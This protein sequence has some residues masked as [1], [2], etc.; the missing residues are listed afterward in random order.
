M[1]PTRRVLTLAGTAIALAAT[2]SSLPAR[3]DDAS[4]AKAV[5]DK[6]AVTVATFAKDPDHASMHT[7]MAKAKAVLVYRQVIEG[8]FIIGGSGGPGVLLVR[9]PATGSFGAPA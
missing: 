5:V 3:A 4:D 7:L 6:A 8:G 9:D 1:K 2:F